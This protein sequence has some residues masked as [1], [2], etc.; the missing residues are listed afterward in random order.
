MVRCPTVGGRNQRRQQRHTADDCAATSLHQTLRASARSVPCVGPGLPSFKFRDPPW[1]LPRVLQTHS[2]QE[3]AWLTGPWPP[4]GLR[5]AAGRPARG[6][7]GAAAGCGAGPRAGLPG[8]RGG[9]REPAPQPLHA[10]GRLGRERP[11]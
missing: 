5:E 2:P 8:E 4:A 7:E 1:P 6:A 10:Q 9:H 3:G 11:R